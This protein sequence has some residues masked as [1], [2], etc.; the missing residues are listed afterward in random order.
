MKKY[1]TNL[2]NHLIVN[3][4]RFMIR[5]VFGLYPG[6]SRYGKW[7]IINGITND[8]KHEDK[9]EFVVKKASNESTNEAA[10]IRAV[11]QEHRVV[12]GLVHP[13]EKV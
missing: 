10:V 12:L 5:A 13:A 9:V 7:A 4:E 1:I 8:R 3:L 2:K 6:I 11:G